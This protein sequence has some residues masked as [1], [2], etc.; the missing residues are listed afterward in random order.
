MNNIIIVT[1]PTASGKTSFAIKLAQAMNS[2]IINADS[3]QVYTENPILSAQPTIEERKAIP[4]HLFGYISGHQEYSVARWI[5]D[6][7]DYINN[8][9][10]SVILVGG[11]GFYL[12]HLIFGLSVIPDISSDI[13]QQARQLLDKIG[14]QEFHQLLQQI[15]PLAA[16]KLDANNSQRVL[17]AYEVIQET[18]QSILNWQKQ[19]I[20]YFPLSSFKVI[21]LLP[22]R[23]ILYQNC[24]QRFL[25]MLELGALEEVKHLLLQQYSPISGIMKSHGVPELGRYLTGEWGLNQ[26]I[27]K[28]QQVV[29]NYAK[30]QLTWCRHQFNHPQ[31]ATY[32]LHQSEQELSQV[33]KFCVNSDLTNILKYT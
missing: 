27:E 19:N 16:S 20:S 29:R 3:L 17:R 12:K 4:H 24:N 21:I 15:D 31:L 32:F 28:S 10:K 33:I 13:R 7:K 23:E 22:E 2:E 8:I 18:G 26:A 30:R 6:T 11:T 14:H 5:E 1:G 9:N 25:D